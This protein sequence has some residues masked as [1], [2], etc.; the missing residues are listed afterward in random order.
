MGSSRGLP[1]G[2]AR[3]NR[4]CRSCHPIVAIAVADFG[5]PW[6]PKAVVSF[7]RGPHSPSFYRGLV[8]SSSHQSLSLGHVTPIPRLNRR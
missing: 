5:S 2:P 3:A 6:M 8:G 1:S 7:G 4:Q